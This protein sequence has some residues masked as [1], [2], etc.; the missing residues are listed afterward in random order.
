MILRVYYSLLPA[1]AKNF[2]VGRDPAGHREATNF[3]SRV[4]LLEESE[5][6][7][8]RKTGELPD[9]GGHSHMSLIMA[10]KRVA[11][12]EAAWASDSRVAVVMSPAFLNPDLN[13]ELNSDEPWR[14]ANR[15]SGSGHVVMQMVRY[16]RGKTYG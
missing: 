12:R 5:A 7:L 9:H 13:P 10:E 14:W 4:C 6:E 15:R 3:M 1:R 8:Y 11:A 16:G 2:R